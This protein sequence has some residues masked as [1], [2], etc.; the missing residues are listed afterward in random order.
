MWQNEYWKFTTKSL[1]RND[2]GTVEICIVDPK[3]QATHVVRL[4]RG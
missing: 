1:L 2:Y 3:I 4:G